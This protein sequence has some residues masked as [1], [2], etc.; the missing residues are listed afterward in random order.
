MTW[1]HIDHAQREQ[2]N[3]TDDCGCIC[4]IIR[5]VIVAACSQW[6]ERRR[7]INPWHWQNFNKILPGQFFFSSTVDFSFFVFSNIQRTRYSAH[8]RLRKENEGYCQNCDS[9]FFFC[10]SL[11][12]EV[13]HPLLLRESEGYCLK[14]NS[15]F[16]FYGGSTP[17]S[18]E[19]EWRLLHEMRFF[20]FFC[21]PLFMEVVHLF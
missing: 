11:S 18:G 10:V 2:N 5:K 3:Q 16:L 1:T 6:K 13:V 19:R 4:R 7:L 8:S 14:C 15:F 12:M 17:I 20:V 21:I 9:S